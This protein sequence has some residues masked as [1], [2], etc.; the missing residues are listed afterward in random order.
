MQGWKDGIVRK[1]TG[2]IRQL[3]KANGVELIQG[4]ARLTVRDAVEVIAQDGSRDTLR[5]Q[6]AIVVATGA[7]TIEIPSL[8]FDGQR[9]IGAREAMSLQ[10]IPKRLC[11]IGGGVIGLEIGRVYQKLGAQLTVVEA[12]PRLLS[13]VDPDCTQVVERKL[14]TAGASILKS[15]KALGYDTQPDGSLRVRVEAEGKTVTVDCDVVLVA[16][17]M[18]PNGGGIGLEQLGVKLQANGAVVVDQQGRTNVPG[19]YAIGDVTGAPLLAHKASKEGE[20]VAEVIAGERAA[21][22]W[23]TI[24]AA[25]FVDPEIAFAGMTADQARDAGHEVK[26]GKFPFAALG[27]AVAMAESDGFVKTVIDAKTHRLLGVHMVGPSVSELV[28]EATLALE[29]GALADDLAL[30][31]HTHP[32]LAEAIME[33]AAHALGHAIHAMNR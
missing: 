22:D 28:A 8:P 10:S 2:G 32:T 13:G 23:V 27:R 14:K 12:L 18:R 26:V 24:P 19:V 3:L 4:I 31:V 15:A 16:V 17:G 33:S 7:T 5:A 11:V 30:T 29:M 1:L 20:V 25:I 21:R 6:K 9:V